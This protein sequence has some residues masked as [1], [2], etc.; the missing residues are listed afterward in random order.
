MISQDITLDSF[1][2]KI[3]NVLYEELFKNL[4]SIRKTVTDCNVSK[5]KI[6]W[7]DT[8]CEDV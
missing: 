6:P 7:Y 8:E 2:D 3:S 4:E 5:F 1:I